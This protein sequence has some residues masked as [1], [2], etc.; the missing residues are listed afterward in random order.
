MV[1]SDISCPP[2]EE[3]L[4]F[5]NSRP[6][7]E[8]LGPHG[9]EMKMLKTKR[10]AEL[11]AYFWPS[12]QGQAK[13]IVICLHGHGSYIGHEMLKIDGVK[14]V[15]KY[16]G[17]WVEKL[18]S[19]GYS[20]AGIDLQGAGRS[21]G[22]R[23]YIDSFDEY[24]EDVLMLAKLVRVKGS[25]GFSPNLPMFLQG[26]SMGG[27]IAT[28]A[29]M[30]EKGL[31]RGV[32]LLAPMLSLAKV[33]AK[34][35]NRLL[36]PL[37][38]ILN[39]L[40][41]TLAVVDSAK[42]TMHPEMQRIFDEDPVC[43]HGPTRVRNA[44][45]Y[46]RVTHELMDDGGL[47]AVDFSFLCFHSENDTMVDCDGSK[48]LMA[49]SPSKDKTLKLVNHMWHVIMKEPGSDEVKKEILDWFDARLDSGINPLANN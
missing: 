31:F 44:V 48:A 17:S 18:N 37:S 24:V 20:A 9:G 10:G 41:P 47:E 4:A 3:T 38:F 28:R 27:C 36:K 39:N 35:I 19:H 40:A 32:V 5:L 49:R 25:S 30:K 21:S 29:A 2:P 45:E 34:L 23:C 6:Q 33:E 16:Q 22:L 12:S 15:P 43:K 8:M 1:S 26:A 13:G 7:S 11:A 42:N 46:L 14:Q